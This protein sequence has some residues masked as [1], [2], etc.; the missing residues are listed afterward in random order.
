MV[1]QQV[2]VL[3]VQVQVLVVQRRKAPREI[4]FGAF[5]FFVDVKLPL[6]LL[7]HSHMEQQRDDFYSLAVKTEEDVLER[8]LSIRV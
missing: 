7:E 4:S 1:T 3:S 2:L 8:C 6:K 5:L